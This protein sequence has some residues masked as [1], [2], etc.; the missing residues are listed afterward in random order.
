MKAQAALEYLM[1]A[2]LVIGIMVTVFA[3]TIFYSSDSISSIQG[4]DAVDN[5]AKTAD[6]AYAL[7]KGSFLKT[8]VIFPEGTLNSSVNGKII[9]ITIRTTSGVSNLIAQTK[10]NVNGSLPNTEGTFV[11]SAN[12]TDPNV[13]LKVVQ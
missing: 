7:G 12:M 10:S 13:T 6:T 5:I 8:T 1:V 3:F 2:G 4:Q 11:I 9:S